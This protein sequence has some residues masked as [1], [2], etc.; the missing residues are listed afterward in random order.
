MTTGFIARIR[1]ARW[2]LV[3][4]AIAVLGVLSAMTAR[5]VADVA[6]VIVIAD[7]AAQASSVWLVEEHDRK[8]QRLLDLD[9]VHVGLIGLTGYI[10]VRCRDGR[11][12]GFDYVTPNI[13]EWST[14]D[15]SCSALR[16]M[17]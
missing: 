2:T 12:L 13:G 11:V 9:R 3:T 17:G 10:E 7:P 16:P 8:T 6:G 4:I 15:P 5:F 1:W 14:L